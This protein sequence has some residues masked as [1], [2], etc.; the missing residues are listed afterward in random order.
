MIGVH[1]SK[2]LNEMNKF[3]KFGLAALSA[4][5]SLAVMAGESSGGTSGA[6]DTEVAT[7]LISSAQTGLT[8]ILGTAGSAVATVLL[9]GLAIW[10]GIA[11][12]GLIKR[13]FNAGKGR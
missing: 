13:S 8:S 5:G 1:L 6:M 3:K 11:I 7:D 4:F 9:A 2:L 12:V 10:A